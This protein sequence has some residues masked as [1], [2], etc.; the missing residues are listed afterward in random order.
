MYGTAN[1]W[2]WQLFWNHVHPSLSSLSSTCG[3]RSRTSSLPLCFDE[4]RCSETEQCASTT[5]REGSTLWLRIPPHHDQD[6]R[7]TQPPPHSDI[8]TKRA[9]KDCIRH[10]QL[11]S[12]FVSQRNGHSIWHQHGKLDGLVEPQ[13]LSGIHFVS[14]GVGASA[15]TCRCQPL[16]PSP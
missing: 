6:G 16:A 7:L 4:V 8:G 1:L 9:R 10:R 14:V 11:Y 15:S 5:R 3:A 2:L 13:F 12:A